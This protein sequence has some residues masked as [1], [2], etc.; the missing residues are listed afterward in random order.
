MAI[1]G[2]IQEKERRVREFLKVRGLQ[3]LLLKRQANF[4]WITGGGLNMVG[5]ATELGNASLLITEKG[6]YVITNNIEAPRMV[7]EERLEKQGYQ[8]RSF[9]WYEDQEL[10]LVREIV[11]RGSV[12]S[13]WPFP[14]GVMVAEEVARLRYSLTPEELVRY[15]WLGG[16]V[17]A[18]LEQTMIATEKGEKES[19]VVGRLCH[20]LWKDRIDPM[21]MMSAADERISRF[22][23]PIPMEKKVEKFLMV[24]VNARK[25]GL[26][27]CL[28]RFIHFGKVPQELKEKYEANVFIDCV[29]MA[30][31]RPGVPAR[32]VLRKGIEAYGAKGYPEEW[33]LHHQGGSIGYNPRDY[34][35]N[36]ETPDV[37]EENQAF[38][39]NPSLTGTKSEDTILA[40]SRG[41][42][43][44]TKPVFFPTLSVETGGLAFVRADILEKD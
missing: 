28:T 43:M 6:K 2:E 4:S 42:E 37:V 44:I 5:I 38:T 30:E 9:P 34:R 25:G 7:E 3:A 31:T 19:A 14:D 26:I 8:V 41:V 22:R 35:V 40:T 39:W 17:S 20:E 18:A 27:V 10:S 11:G 12:G 29:F 16:R 21:G 36:L 13:D 33:K 15:R 32:E 24:S 1:L 23:H